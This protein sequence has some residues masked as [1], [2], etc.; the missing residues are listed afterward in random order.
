MLILVFE[1]IS[2]QGRCR[3]ILEW[4]WCTVCTVWWYKQK[5]M[6]HLMSKP[7]KWHVHPAKTQISLGIRPVWSVFTVRMKKAWVLSYRLSYPLNAQRR[8]W[9]AQTDL[10]LRWAHSHFV[11]F[12][13]RRLIFLHPVYVIWSKGYINIT[14][15]GSKISSFFFLWDHLPLCICV[16]VC[17]YYCNLSSAL[18]FAFGKVEA[19]SSLY[20]KWCI[21][22]VLF[23][24]KQGNSV[25]TS[26]HSVYIVSKYEVL[27]IVV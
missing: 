19:V 21:W 18:M 26:V 13:V 23:F 17:R 4:T 14:D 8:L 24:V 20:I 2:V 11:G 10:S 16:C 12:V 3:G 22:F 15:L 6:S 9:S 7:T 5:K 25:G 27:Y 1:P